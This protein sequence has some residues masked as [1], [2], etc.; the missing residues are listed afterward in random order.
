MNNP[1][2]SWINVDLGAIASNFHTLQQFVTKD[3][4][5]ICVIKAD[6]YKLGSIPIAHTLKNAG[7]KTFGVAQIK[8]GIELRQ[9]GINETILVLS[10]PLPEELEALVT[11][12]LTATVSCQT[13]LERLENIGKKM[14]KFIPIQLKIDTGMGR[15]GVWHT[16]IHSLYQSILKYSHIQLKGIFTHLP[17]ASTDPDYTENQ[18]KKFLYALKTI[19]QLN[20]SH[21]QIHAD[22]SPSLSY[23][24]ITPPIN[25]VR[26]G[27]F[28]FNLTSHIPL[29]KEPLT[30][31]FSLH[32][33]IAL[34]K[35]LPSKTGISYGLTHILQRPSRVAIISIGYADGIRRQLINAY[36]LIKGQRCPILGLTSMD[37]II[38]DV[39]DLPQTPQAG[40]TATLIGKQEKEEITLENFCQ[41]ANIMP[42]EAVC[43]FSNRIHRIYL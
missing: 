17:V 15:L 29:W 3:I 2:R 22:I 43:Q 19:P 36:V 41:F 27:S 30:P 5:I 4:H 9:N 7:A 13:T 1:Y 38:V 25:T 32:A 16:E 40:D 35:N 14:G 23:F 10:D 26:I 42:L 8:E 20:L 6:A 31:V 28:L 34:V 37:Q 39:T 21:L 12:Q 18:K 33:K 11:Y 24:Q